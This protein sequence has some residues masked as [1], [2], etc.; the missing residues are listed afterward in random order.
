MFYIN[1]FICI[2]YLSS[3]SEF[4]QYG[5]FHDISPF[6]HCNSEIQQQFISS[7]WEERIRDSQVD[8]LR[9]ISVVQPNLKWKTN[10]RKTNR[11]LAKIFLSSF[12]S[13]RIEME[14]WPKIKNKLSQDDPRTECKS[15]P[16]KFYQR[17][18]VNRWTTLK[19]IFRSKFSVFFVCSK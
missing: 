17:R 13:R 7:S 4:V 3:S 1:G 14:T 19:E 2:S 6:P 12:R 11:S 16:T 10:N 15:V 18:N 5:K 9:T 8:E